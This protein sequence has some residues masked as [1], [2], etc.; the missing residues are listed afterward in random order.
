MQVPVHT[1]SRSYRFQ[2]IQ[3]PGSSDLAIRNNVLFVNQATD[4]ITLV[5]NSSSADLTLSKR[6]KNTFPELTS[7]EGQ[8]P[9]NTP[10]DSV[11]IDWVPKTTNE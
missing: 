1:G 11:V 5:Y 3:V 4:L 9:Y 8:R 7:P 10:E 6:I 2:F